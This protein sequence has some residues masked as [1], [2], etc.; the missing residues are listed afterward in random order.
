MRLRSIRVVNY[1]GFADS[2]VLDVGPHWTVVVGR[3]NA[4]KSAL[5][6]AFSAG[7]LVNRP[8]RNPAQNPLLPRDPESVVHI[9]LEVSGRELEFTFLRAGFG[10]CSIPVPDG[11]RSLESVENDFRELDLL[12]QIHT[13]GGTSDWWAASY[14]SHNRFSWSNS[15]QMSCCLVPRPDRQSWQPISFYQNA[16][17]SIPT[18]AGRALADNTYIFRAERRVSGSSPMQDTLLLRPDASNLAGALNYLYTSD[19]VRFQHYFRLVREVLP[20]VQSV[21][22]PPNGSN[23]EIRVWNTGYEQS[24]LDL[25]IPLEQCGTGIGQVLAILFVAA[26]ADSGRILVIDEPN[27]FLHPRASRVLMEVLKRFQQHQFVITSHSPELIASTQPEKLVVMK[28]C[29][30]ASHA[31][32]YD[33]KAVAGIQSAF[34]ELGVRVSD[35][36]GYDAVAWV[37]GKTEEKCFPIIVEASGASIPTR[38]AFVSVAKTDGLDRL[39]ADVLWDA[40]KALASQSP[41]APAAVSIS[42]DRERRTDELC[43]TLVTKSKG[44]LQFLPRRAYENYLLDPDA[45]A[46]VLTAEDVGRVVATEDVSEWLRRHIG[47]PMYLRGAPNAVNGSTDWTS[48]VDAVRILSDMIG[49]LTGHTQ[50]YLGRKVYFAVALTTWLMKHAPHKLDELTRYVLGLLTQCDEPTRPG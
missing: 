8:H 46:A 27:S 13:K 29:D 47:D 14:P 44:L 42:L 17:D 5:L 23:V 49:D 24:R 11:Q 12:L 1:K 48:R 30:D 20:E 36:F 39:K 21:S 15:V 26:T 2:C 4:G 31:Q 35:V 32:V 45:I 28:W 37:E 50:D 34:D 22:I 16:N 18:L 38:M 40:Y 33:G 10:D 41:F 3:N 7:E 43:S 25:A 19:N 9:S 6:E